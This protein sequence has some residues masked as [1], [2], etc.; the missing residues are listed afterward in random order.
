MINN[1]IRPIYL[2][3]A[4]NQKRGENFYDIRFMQKCIILTDLE[5]LSFK[6]I[7]DKEKEETITKNGKILKLEL[8]RVNAVI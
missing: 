4:K 2:N 8:S 6:E 3:I 5:S 7:I 1:A